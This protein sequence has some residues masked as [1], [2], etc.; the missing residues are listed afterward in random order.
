FMDAR[1]SAPWCLRSEQNDALCAA[2]LPRSER[3]VSF[4]F[5]IQGEC[6][7]MLPDDPAG[8]IALSAGDILVVPRG[9]AHIIG[10]ARDLQAVPTDALL[11][12]KVEAAA[13]EVM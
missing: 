10:S 12:D 3:I 4:H 11:A 5:I 9:E 13:G 8:A 6:W 1:F 2:Y 7:A